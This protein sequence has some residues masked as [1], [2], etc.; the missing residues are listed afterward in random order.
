MFEVRLP[1]LPHG[2]SFTCDHFA[3][4]IAPPASRAEAGGELHRPPA[5]HGAAAAAAHVPPSLRWLPA[6][7]PSLLS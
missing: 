3:C 1:L 4:N 2:I 7:L 6:G 5:R